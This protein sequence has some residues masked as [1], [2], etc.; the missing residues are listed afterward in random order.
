[1]S[2]LTSRVGVLRRLFRP[3]A[4]PRP[5][6]SSLQLQRRR[7]APHV[8]A[9]SREASRRRYAQSLLFRQ[10][11]GKTI[12]Q[13]KTSLVLWHNF[14]EGFQNNLTSLV[15]R[16]LSKSSEVNAGVKGRQLQLLSLILAD[17]SEPTDML[18]VKLNCE[19]KCEWW[20]VGGG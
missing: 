12:S 19:T 7:H 4:V 3:H 1:M 6:R 9:V 8:P 17:M 20:V 16:E 10:L 2:R 18:V 11:H 14:L 15:D 13:H 5:V